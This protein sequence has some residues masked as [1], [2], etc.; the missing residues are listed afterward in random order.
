MKYLLINVG[1]LSTNC[2]LLYEP[3]TKDAVI[4]DPGSE[5]EK[6][7]NI[8]EENGLKPKKILLTHGHFDHILAV[9]ALVKQYDIPVFCG[10]NEETMLGNADLNVSRQMNRTIEL[11]PDGTFSDGE[12][13]TVLGRKMRVLFT[14]GHTEGSVCYYFPEDGWLFSGDT[15]FKGTYG[16][17]DFPTGDFSELARSIRGILFS[18]PAETVVFPGHM[19]ETTIGI[20]RQRGI[21]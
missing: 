7:T 6:I 5:A 12:E 14:P 15:L 8:I 19:A 9:P 1:P 20:E 3:E 17:T 21:I 2:Y 4:V 16:R 18:L 10:E 13:T 11:T